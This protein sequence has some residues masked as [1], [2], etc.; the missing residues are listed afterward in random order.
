M[1]RKIAFFFEMMGVAPMRTLEIAH[2]SIY[3]GFLP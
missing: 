3:S 2:A 1:N